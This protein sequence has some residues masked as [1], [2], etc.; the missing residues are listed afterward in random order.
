MDTDR[1]GISD[2]NILPASIVIA[3]IIIAGAFVYDIPSNSKV[4]KKISQEEGVILP[5]IW[6][7]LGIKLVESGTIDGDKFSKLYSDRGQFTDE[8]KKLLFGDDNGRLKVTKENSGYLLNLLWAFGLAN[9]S[10]ILE[11]GEMVDPRYGGPQNFASTG[12]W[13]MAKGHVMGHYSKHVL[14]NLTIEQEE[15]VDKI[16]RLIYRPCCSNST[17][18]P[19]CNHGMAMLGLLELMASQGVGEEEM[20]QNAIAL[21]SYWFP[22]YY[23]DEKPTG[24][25]CSV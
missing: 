1:Q 12:G 25:G 23:D 2:K 22:G 18:F 10:P 20:Y 16:S 17:H 5:A 9:K 7:D 15:M 19:D 14:V 11:N 24:G 8:Y 4:L 3:G 13:T 21:N 6:G